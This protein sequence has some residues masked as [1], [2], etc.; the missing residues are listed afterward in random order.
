[1]IIT[2]A[3]VNFVSGLLIIILHRSAWIKVDFVFVDCF[4]TWR[5][6][7]QIR[8][9]VSG[10]ALTWSHCFIVSFVFFVDFIF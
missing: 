5:I 6:S 1:M 7:R 10:L 4:C 2:A 3:V 9:R 8:L